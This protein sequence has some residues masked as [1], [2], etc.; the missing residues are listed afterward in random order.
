MAAKPESHP[1]VAAVHAAPVF[2]NKDATIDKVLKC[3]AD[4]GS[5]TDYLVFPEVFVPGYPV[6][7]VLVSPPYHSTAMKQAYAYKASQYFIECYPPLNQVRALAQYAEQSVRVGLDG[8]ELRPVMEACKNLRVAVSLGISERIVDGH[9]LF[10]SQ[11]FIDQ[12]GTL[13]GVHRKL[14]PTYVERAVWA[15]G[16]GHTLRTWPSS[17][18]RIGGLV[19]WENTMNLARQALIE[20][21][22]I[23]HAGAW[24]AL[25]SMKGFE[26]V[27]DAQIEALM[28]NHA[29]TGQCFVVCASNYVDESCLHWM[30][31]HLGPQELVKRGGGWSAVIHPFC[32]FLAGPVKGDG[33]GDTLVEAVIDQRELGQVKVWIDANGHYKRPEILKL[34]VCRGAMWADDEIAAEA[35]KYDQGT[36]DTS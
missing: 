5:S 3:I 26:A 25:S 8:G 17:I 22:Q 18:G 13:L 7:P 33:R 20:E 29:L 14:Q 11:V 27:A 10:N 16:S 23:I 2:M 6:S 9:T 24:P 1:R 30:E 36:K 12:D 19:C 35:R 28:K 34:D 31:E 4:L 32:S 15:Q 21:G